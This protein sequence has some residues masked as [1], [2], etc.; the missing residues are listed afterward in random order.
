MWS[1]RKTWYNNTRPQSAQPPYTITIASKP[2]QDIM[3]IQRSTS[4]WPQHVRLRAGLIWTLCLYIEECATTGTFSKYAIVLRVLEIHKKVYLFFL[5]FFKSLIYY[6]NFFSWSLSGH[7]H[8][9]FLHQSE[10]KRWVM[11]RIVSRILT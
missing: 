6:S 7:L 9:R 4:T 5:I 11:V 1:F 10:D 3:Y 8:V 2:V